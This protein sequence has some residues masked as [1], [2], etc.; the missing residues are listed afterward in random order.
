MTQLA[1]LSIVGL[2]KEVT[3]GTYVAPTAFIPV[4]KYDFEDAFTEIKDTSIRANDTLL[5]NM[6]QGVVHGNWTIDLLAY[7]DVSGHFLRSIIGPDTVTPGVSTTLSSASIAGATSLSSVAS[8][9]ANT[10]IQ[11]DVAPNIE[12]AKVTAVSGVGPFTLTVTGAGPTGGMLFAHLSAAT[13]V[14]QTTHTFKQNPAPSAKAT[15][16]LTAYDTTQT[17]GYPGATASDLNIKIDPKAAITFSLKYQTFPGAV[18]PVMTPTFTQLA[19]FLGWQW[20]MTN[21]GAASTRGLTYDVNIKRGVTTIH[22]SDGIQAPREIFQSAIEAD[23]KYKAIFENQ[24]DMNLYTQYSQQAATATVQAPVS[25]GGSSV[26]LTMS[27]SGWMKGKRSFA[28][29]YVEGDYDIQGIYNATDG[30]AI[31]AVLM[32]YLTA[33]Y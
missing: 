3:P 22:S 5:Q 23:G 9:A 19:P 18:Q 15:Y 2:A 20:N 12:W 25:A 4:M 26:S 17:L 32:N 29:A 31:S 8:V 21:A 30:G 28:S 7:P 10:Y 13:V 27:K 14:S 24:A 1:R 33:A 6:Y 11:V 16:S